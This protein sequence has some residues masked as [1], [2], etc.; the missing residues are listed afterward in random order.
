MKNII[1]K[2]NIF[3][4]SFSKPCSPFE[5]SNITS[6]WI[7]YKESLYNVKKQVNNSY[8]INSDKKFTIDDIKFNLLISLQ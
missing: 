1:I 2:N 5:N 8:K 7:L 6:D 3:L 4:D